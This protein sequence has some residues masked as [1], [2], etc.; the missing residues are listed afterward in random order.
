M[1]G[2]TR[3]FTFHFIV[4]SKVSQSAV[5]WGLRSGSYLEEYIKDT[6]VAKYQYLYKGSKFYE[7]DIVDEIIEQVRSGHHVFIDWKSNLQYIM[8]TEYLKT[9]RCDFTYSTDE[10]MEEQIAIVMPPNSPYLELINLEIKRLHQSGFIERWLKEYLPRR[11]RCWRSSNIIEVE[12][13]TVTVDDMQGSFL[14]L[15]IG[16]AG[17][18]FF[19]L[20]ECMWRYQRK[21][22]QSEVIKPFIE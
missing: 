11:D 2:I 22:M 15:S 4:T 1:L 14:V 21:R 16:F 19:F 13:H 10:F 8:K 20:I 17:G 18:F 3:F 5:S 9:D 7:G 6:D 12:N